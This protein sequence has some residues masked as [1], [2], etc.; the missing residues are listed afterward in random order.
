MT[1]EVI[2]YPSGTQSPDGPNQGLDH[3]KEVF[4][5]HLSLMALD[6]FKEQITISRWRLF[7]RRR[8][9]A[10]MGAIYQAQTMIQNASAKDLNSLVKEHD[11]LMAKM[12][13]VPTGQHSIR[14][15]SELGYSSEMGSAPVPDQPAPLPSQPER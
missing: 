3:A 9:A 14:A 7:A 15:S 6:S 8:I 10:S 12:G 1:N 2:G 11:R 13:L 4:L 5:Q